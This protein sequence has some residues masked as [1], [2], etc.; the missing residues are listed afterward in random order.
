M[1]N[2]TVRRAYLCMH[3]DLYSI[4]HAVYNLATHIEPLGG[5]C[6]VTHIGTWIELAKDEREDVPVKSLED[7]C[8]EQTVTEGE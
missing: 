7:V 6:I 8:N 5:L 2:S 3:M 4:Y 1:Q